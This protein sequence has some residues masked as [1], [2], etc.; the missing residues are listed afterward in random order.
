MVKDIYQSYRQLRKKVRKY[1]PSFCGN[2]SKLT[3]R[4][5]FLERPTDLEYLVN[6][7]LLR[8]NLERRCLAK[9]ISFN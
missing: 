5:Y 6:R 4:Y 8:E 1:F 3:Y 2:Y 9:Y 7:R